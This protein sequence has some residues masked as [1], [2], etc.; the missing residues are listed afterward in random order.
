MRLA[1]SAGAVTIGLTGFDGG[2]LKDLVDLCITVPNNSIEQVEDIH[3]LL[4]HI[5][6]TCLRTVP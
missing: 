5:I 4:E 1:R 3:L 6:T 2:E